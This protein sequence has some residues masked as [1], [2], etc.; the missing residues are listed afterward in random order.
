MCAAAADPTLTFLPSI[1]LHHFISLAKL[2]ITY[3]KKKKHLLAE[4]QFLL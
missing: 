2:A 4:A 1:T 3:S